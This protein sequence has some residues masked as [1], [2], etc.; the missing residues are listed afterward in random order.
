M[1][2]EELNI[3][4]LDLVI[5][6][7]TMQGTVEFASKNNMDNILNSKSVEELRRMKAEL[8]CSSYEVPYISDE[9]DRKNK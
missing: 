5:G 1:A 2:K 6:G 9:Q 3:E 8:E 7:A 4:Q